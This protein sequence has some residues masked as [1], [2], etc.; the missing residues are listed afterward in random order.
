MMKPSTQI[1]AESMVSI[2]S[3]ETKPGRSSRGGSGQNW[4][5]AFFLSYFA[6]TTLMVLWQ[7]ESHHK[8]VPCST[9]SCSVTTLSFQCHSEAFLSLFAS[10]LDFMTFTSTCPL[11]T[12][13]SNPKGTLFLGSPGKRINA[14]SNFSLSFS[15]IFINH[16]F[17]CNGHSPRHNIALSSCNMALGIHLPLTSDIIHLYIESSREW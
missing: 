2:R 6:Y 7:W 3:E 5:G 15:L 16:S 8:G 10:Y 11:S 1:P 13:S 14:G 12:S 9:P 4:I 17:H